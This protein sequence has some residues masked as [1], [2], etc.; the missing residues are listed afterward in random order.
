MEIRNLCC[1][2]GRRSIVKDISFSI[3]KGEV[4]C[5]LGANGSGKTTLLKTILG[6]LKPQKGEI[7]LD[8]T[9]IKKWSCS[10][11]ARVIGYIPQA[12]EPPFPFQVRDVVLMG[13]TAHLAPF[14]SPSKRDEEIA[15]K[16]MEI[17]SITHLRERVYTEISGGERQLVLI[18]RALTQEPQILIMDE[19]TSSLDFGNQVKVLSQVQHLAKM[20]MGVVMFCHFPEHAF[21]Y[22]TK[23]MLLDKGEMLHFDIPEKAITEESLKTLYGVD[24][25]IVSVNNQKNREVKVCIPSHSLIA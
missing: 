14:A 2:Y 5:L 15:E 9:N 20:N 12:H 22:S 17:L 6:L 13:R 10:Q 21:L 11:I 4:I 8:N 7:F 3:D 19:P 16:A 18:A 25:E 23:V 1:G 24:L